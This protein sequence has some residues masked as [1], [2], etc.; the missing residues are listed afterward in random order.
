LIYQANEEDVVPIYTVPA[1]AENM[2]PFL[3][4]KYLGEVQHCFLLL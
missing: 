1:W 4:L 2:H 3:L